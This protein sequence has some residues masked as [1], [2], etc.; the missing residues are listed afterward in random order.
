[1]APISSLSCCRLITLHTS[2]TSSCAKKFLNLHEPKA[3]FPVGRLVPLSGAGISPAGSIRLFLTHCSGDE[4]RRGRALIRCC[5]HAGCAMDRSLLVEKLIRP[6]L[7]LVGNA[8][9]G[10][11][12]VNHDELALR[13]SLSQGVSASRLFGIATLSLQ[14]QRRGL[15]CVSC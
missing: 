9:L 10:L 7:I 11:G 12:F 13:I 15:A 4:V 2:Q 5:P 3:R 6:Q 1:V 8:V 14:W